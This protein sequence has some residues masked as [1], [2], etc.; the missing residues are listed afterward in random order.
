[1]SQVDDPAIPH[2]LIGGKHEPQRVQVVVH[3]GLRSLDLACRRPHDARGTDDV[4]ADIV[5]LEGHSESV[6]SGVIRGF[7][8]PDKHGEN[9]LLQPEHPAEGDIIQAN[10]VLHDCEAN[11]YKMWYGGGHWTCYATSA[12]GLSWDK[13]D[14]GLVEHEGS[15]RNNLVDGIVG[16]IVFTPE[17]RGT[18]PH[19]STNKMI[20]PSM[21]PSRQWTR[22]IRSFGVG[23]EDRHRHYRYRDFCADD[24]VAVDRVQTAAEIS[25]PVEKAITI[26]TGLDGREANMW[27][28]AE[29]EALLAEGKIGRDGL[30]GLDPLPQCF[31]DL[32]LESNTLVDRV[33]SRQP[34]RAADPGTGGRLRRLGRRRSRAH[35][36]NSSM[37]RSLAAES[38]RVSRAHRDR[39]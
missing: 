6:H 20:P 2:R 17:L 3:V 34:G 7:H 32:S 38:A 16:K 18:E 37:N 26:E 8:Q 24:P 15:T 9:P 39:G 33:P 11:L 29:A 35:C 5:G 30:H 27:A 4:D 28:F 36:L 12:D 23:D 22:S 21:R 31:L 25:G 1:M 13:P 10:A 14:L 19:G